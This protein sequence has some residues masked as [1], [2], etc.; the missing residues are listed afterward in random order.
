MNA[1]KVLGLD[2]VWS[3][4]PY[5][6]FPVIYGLTPTKNVYVSTTLY[7]FIRTF[8]NLSDEN[9]PIEN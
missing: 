1:L 2:V 9:N 3:K 7:V 8:L 5:L 4:L 6:G